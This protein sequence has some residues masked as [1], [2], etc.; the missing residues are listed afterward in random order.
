MRI[1]ETHL[2]D[3]IVFPTHADVH[4]RA[5]EV[6]LVE[7]CELKVLSEVSSPIP[8]HGTLYSTVSAARFE[9]LLTKHTIFY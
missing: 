8:E 2:L 5:T 1:I 4:M 7:P 3:I 9:N 6:S